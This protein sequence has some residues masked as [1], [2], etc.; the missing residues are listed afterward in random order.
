MTTGLDVFDT[1]LQETN[2]WLKDLMGCLGTDD[3]RQGYRALRAVLHA[4]RDRIGPEN[5]VHLGAQL[6]MLVRGL[7]Y[8]GWKMD[9]EP[10]R[11]RHKEA[12]LQHVDAEARN[13]LGV[14][15]EIAVHAVFEVLWNRIDP[16]EV[17]KVIHL[18]P[19]ELR[20]FWPR[21]ARADD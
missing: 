21:V 16:D 3:R 11:E 15:A 13:S 8:E 17:D 2:L 6:P 20:E 19:V 4:V 7:Y 12:F 14:D 1:T 9:P 5:A 10:T 18:F